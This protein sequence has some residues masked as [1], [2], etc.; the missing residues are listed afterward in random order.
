MK[1][2][3]A[4]VFLASA[5]SASV[6]RYLLKDRGFKTMCLLATTACMFGAS[7]AMDSTLSLSEKNKKE[8]EQ[9]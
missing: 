8:N 4:T 3:L 9:C 1:Y 2:S 5:Y 7:F 6:S